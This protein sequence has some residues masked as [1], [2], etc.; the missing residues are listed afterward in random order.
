MD[1]HALTRLARDGAAHAVDHADDG[2]TL[3]LQFLHGHQGVDGLA[4]LADGH[5][6]RVPFDDRVAVAE[7]CRRFGVGRD[8]SELLD[9]HRAE[10]TG[11]VRRPAAEDLHPPDRAQLAQVD[12]DAAEPGSRVAFVEAAAQRL[13]Q[14]A[15]LFV[16]L[17]LHEAVEVT[18]V[19][20][21]GGDRLGD[22]LVRSGTRD[23]GPEAVGPDG[24][25]LTVAQVR[26]VR[27]APDQSRLVGRDQRGVLG[28]ADDDRAAVAGD[29]ELVGERR[30]QH[31]EAVGA[32]DGLQRGPDRVFEGGSPVQQSPSDELGQH[33]GVGLG[34]ELH[35]VGRELGA[36]AVGVLDDAVVHHR[37]LFGRV[38][39]RMRIGLARLTV[40]GPPGVRD[41][42]A[43]RVASV[44]HGAQVRDTSQR[45][46]TRQRVA[47]DDGQACRV[48]TAVFQ[49]LQTLEQGGDRRRRISGPDDGDDAAH[50]RPPAPVWPRP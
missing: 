15:G 11:V 22:V 36:Q 49:A 26:H 47:V 34:R 10:L 1:E 14:S 32:D 33:L 12:V 35:A 41:A 6:Q 31:D 5:V 7:L 48:V 25:H 18:Q 17:L 9:G 8:A 21:V 37:D 42:G 4:G 29:D 38:D 13:R 46:R 39:L 28:E 43:R 30:R 24:D 20:R 50:V 23:D 45:L 44:G 19:E 27:R 16:D 2:R 40:G 3:A